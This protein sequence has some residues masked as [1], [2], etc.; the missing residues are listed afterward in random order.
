MKNERITKVINSSEGDMNLYHIF[1]TTNV[2]LM[3]VLEEKSEDH[4]SH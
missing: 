1:K 3:V 2:N 4:Q